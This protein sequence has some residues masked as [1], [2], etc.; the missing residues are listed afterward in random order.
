M[1]ERAALTRS[2]DM[3]G[4]SW[5]P[6]VRVA[7]FRRTSNDWPCGVVARVRFNFMSCL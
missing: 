4:V 7:R 3:L 6:G 1:Q 2:W 5:L